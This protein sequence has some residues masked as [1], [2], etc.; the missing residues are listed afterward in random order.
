MGNWLGHVGSGFFFLIWASWWVLQLS[1]NTLR[2]KYERDGRAGVPSRPL[3]LC[4][5][6]PLEGII[7]CLCT[8]FGFIAENMYPYTRWKMFDEEGNFIEANVWQHCTIWVAF[9]I[10]GLVKILAACCCV[11]LKP[12]I[13]VFRTFSFF[14]Q[15]IVFLNHLKDRDVLNTKLHVLLLIAILLCVLFS[16]MEIWMKKDKFLPFM[17][18]WATFVN[19]TWLIQVGCALYPI[20]TGR[21]QWKPDD[22]SVKFFTMIFAWH[23][24]GNVISV[25]MLYLIVAIA[26]KFTFGH[27]RGYSQLEIGEDS[28]NEQRSDTMYL[29]RL[30]GG[31][32]SQNNWSD[33]SL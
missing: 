23:C 28:D 26:M 6:I 10:F 9:W 15:S 25:V 30:Q 3:R 33:N 17:R 5:R 29:E 1:F 12:W 11:N 2:N 22:Q 24:I 13:P 16:G 20:R 21:F 4:R 31:N 27:K 14:I 32:R 18:M 19:G 8:A 7:I